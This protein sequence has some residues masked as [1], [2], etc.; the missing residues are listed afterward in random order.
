VA[1]CAKC[2][3]PLPPAARFCPACAH[4]VTAERPTEERKLA[5]VLFADLVGSTALADSQDA[6][7]TRALLNRFYDAMASEI[8][9][10]GGTV[11]KFIGDAVMAAFGAP[12]SQEDH[13]ERALHAALSMRETLAGLFGDKLQLRIGVNTGDV[14]VGEPRVGSSFVTGDAVN[15]AARLEQSAAPGEILVGERTLA[16]SRTTFDFGPEATVE[17]KG[18]AALVVCRP[19]LGAA[20]SPAE[21][22]VS[23]SFVGR[24]G[25]LTWLQGRYSHVA[26]EGHAAFV[27]M[28]GEPGIGKSTLVHEFRD[29]LST[30]SPVPAERFSRCL[31]FGQASAYAP[32]GDIVRPHR[33]LLGRHPILGLAFGQP[34]P[35]G[36][37]P[38]AVRE[39]LRAAWLEL[40]TEL[41]A[42]GPAVVIVEDLHWAEPEM[43]ELLEE[44]SRHASWPMLLLGTAR[45]GFAPVG[46]TIRLDPL[47]S[48]DA[49]RLVDRLA[50]DTMTEEVRTFVVDRADGN[51]FFVEELLRMLADE[52]VTHDI[53][54][55]LTIPDTVQALLAARIDLLSPEAKSA[56]QAAAVIGR[57]FTVAPVRTLID[58]APQLDPLVGR[59]FIR[60]G[61]GRFTFMHALTRDVA[62]GSLTTARRARLHARYADWLE[63]AS[64]GADESAA[65]LAHHYA[66][67]VRPEDEDLAWPG[68]EEELAR[69]RSRAVVWL[70]RA[71]Q[72]AVRRYEIADAVELLLRAVELEHERGEQI[73]IWREIAHAHVLNFDGD[74][75]AAS[76]QQAIALSSEDVAAAD[77]Y[78]ELAFQTMARAGMWGTPPPSDLIE[79]WITQAL[80]LAAEE[81]SARAKALIARCYSA[82][83]K[84]ARD[85]AEASQLGE[86]LDDPI[87]RSYGYDV[88]VLVAFVSGNYAEALEWSR[89][90]VS[91]A[92]ELGDPDTEAYVYAN[93]VNPAVA[94]GE[95]NEAR[96]YAALQEEVTR[97]LSPHHRLHGVSGLLELEELFGDWEAALE[98]Q[99]SVEKAVEE[100]RTT[101]CVRNCRSLLVCA[102]AHAHLDNDDEAR[103]FERA[104]EAHAMTGYG[105]VLDTPRLLLA[106]QRNDLAAVESLLGEPA[107][108]ATNWFYLSS[109]AAHLDGLAAIGAGDRVE[110]DASRV[111]RPG[112]YLEPFALR[113]LGVVRQDETMIYQAAGRFEAFGL[114]WH[115]ARTRALL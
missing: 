92:D 3:A 107:V 10:A 13:V 113:A 22:P 30:Q 8:S 108:R 16:A 69:V 84:S 40:L 28:L 46:E 102:L 68:K 42:A 81:S 88:R 23:S 55:T 38:L 114:G 9:D 63:S 18:K 33:E 21:R 6:E 52:R 1:A 34:V 110:Q 101:P 76:L 43:H 7:R 14:I 25:E 111:L 17:A 100:N 95:V 80:G 44:A 64:G 105:T 91:I 83:D 29:W 70:R 2:G 31:S 39:H 74:R 61:D 41:T 86:A 53:P 66:E 112:T 98:L 85:A 97:T 71:A 26:G 72:L 27:T 99:A 4:P 109:M 48:G 12:L 56:L 87:L 15:V 62:Y 36:L 5:T 57:T 104:A 94:C 20:A 79:G 54:R 49:E 51:P 90:R 45:G 75:F 103:R 96:R 65:E 19:L 11:E 115:A 50:P 32:L 89:R 93:A 59:G 47:P 37:H 67:A 82:Y 24:E 58:D 35:T 78:A 73:E 77:L 106:L 60:N